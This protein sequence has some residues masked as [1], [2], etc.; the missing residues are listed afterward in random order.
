MRIPHHPTAPVTEFE[1]EG[2]KTLSE[3]QRSKHYI[4]SSEEDKQRAKDTGKS[5]S[6]IRR[7]ACAYE[8]DVGLLDRLA[9]F[10]W[11][12][13][14]VLDMTGG[15]RRPWEIQ[16]VADVTLPCSTRWQTRPA[17][18]HRYMASILRRE[19]NFGAD[20]DVCCSISAPRLASS[21]YSASQ[22][23]W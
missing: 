19:L 7:R 8:N 15:V 9:V 3:D 17:P 11:D 20:S 10:K 1:K 6:Y 23:R 18:T 16:A 21:S 22:A 13:D 5:K 14:G 4:L 2:M 12:G